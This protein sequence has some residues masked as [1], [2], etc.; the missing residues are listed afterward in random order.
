MSIE[1]GNNYKETLRSEEGVVFF[2]FFC[3]HTVGSD[4]IKQLLAWI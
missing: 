1:L 3:R 4:Y 2:V